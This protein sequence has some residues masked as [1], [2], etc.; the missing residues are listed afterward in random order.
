MPT[1]ISLERSGRTQ[2]QVG[3]ACH[4]WQISSI[5]WLG[6]H[7]QQLGMTAV[8]H[9]VHV[10]HGTKRLH[11]VHVVHL[12]LLPGMQPY[13]MCRCNN[14]TTRHHK[15]GLTCTESI[16]SPSTMCIT[17][18]HQPQTLCSSRTRLQNLA[19]KISFG[20]HAARGHNT[21][22]W[23]CNQ[24]V[25]YLIRQHHVL[26]MQ[27][28]LGASPC[29][30]STARPLLYLP[31]L[32]SPGGPTMYTPRPSVAQT[33]PAGPEQRPGH[34]LLSTRRACSE[35]LCGLCYL[36]MLSTKATPCSTQWLGCMSVARSASITSPTPMALRRACVTY[37]GARNV[38]ASLSRLASTGMICTS[39]QMGDSADHTPASHPI[40]KAPRWQHPG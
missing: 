3:H 38:P 31:T 13:Q 27:L 35:G 16:Y 18:P 14:S 19:K 11:S 26:H 25:H 4:I 5:T 12:G 9:S 36:S 15:N 39:K 37:T 1:Q 29:R 20:S 24:V 33:R 2:P 7:C 40:A 17:T 10:P 8:L 34:P 32:L 6:R 23:L 22:T 30:C 21:A 28:A